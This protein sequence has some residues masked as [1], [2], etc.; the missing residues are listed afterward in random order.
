MAKKSATTAAYDHSDRCIKNELRAEFEQM[1]KVKKREILS[2]K[3]FGNIGTKIFKINSSQRI[4][5]I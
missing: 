3:C 2:H 4:C 5:Q 1:G